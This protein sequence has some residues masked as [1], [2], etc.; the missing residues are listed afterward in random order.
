MSEKHKTMLRIDK[1]LHERLVAIAKQENRTVNQQITL[2]I[3]Q[4][5]DSRV[6][7]SDS[8]GYCGN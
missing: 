5:L 7:Q 6:S 4:G 3:R 2:F 8:S 1:D